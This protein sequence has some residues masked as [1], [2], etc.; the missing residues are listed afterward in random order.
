MGFGFQRSICVALLLL[1]LGVGSLTHSRLSYAAYSDADLK[2]VYL[3]RFALLINWPDRYQS[4]GKFNYCAYKRSE[5]SQRLQQITQ[6]KAERARFYLLDDLDHRTNCHVIFINTDDPNTVQTLRTNNPNS[7]IV[8]N[9]KDF[10]RHGGMVAFI[11]NDNRIKPL[12]SLRNVAD[13][14]FQIRAPLLQVSEIWE[15]SPL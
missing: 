7:L 9:G 3:F 15:D 4:L 13:A 14:P 12:I 1:L 11:K 10:I 5:T 2:A 8:G 6:A